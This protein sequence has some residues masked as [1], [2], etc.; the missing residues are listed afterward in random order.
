M[1][2]LKILEITN[3]TA[4]GCGVG[5]RVL[6]ESSLLVKKGYQVQIFSSFFVKGSNEIASKGEVIN[7]V[8]I[9][10]FPAKKLGG[11]SFMIWNFESEALKFNPDIIIVHAYRHIHTTR[12]LKIAKKL[13]AK[14]FLVTHAPFDR[15]STRTLFQRGTVFFYDQFIGKKTLKRFDKIIA[16]TKWEIPFILNLGLTRDKIEYIPNGIKDE[17]FRNN[18]KVKEENKIIYMGRISPIKNLKVMIKAIPLLD[19]TNTIFEIIGPCENNYLKKLVSLIKDI[20]LENRVKI[21]NKNYIYQEEIK[22]LNSAKFFILPSLSEGMPQVLVEAMALGKVVIASN[23]KGNADLIIDGKNGFLFKN[24]DEKDLA[25]KINK[26]SSIKK[27]K[28][29]NI[30]KEAKKTASQFSW[31]KIINKIEELINEKNK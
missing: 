31:D 2:K 13:N 11:E 15:N 25:E 10:R 30:K 26:I 18:K 9:K 27:D 22:Q 5:A 8:Q 28:F 29:N 19:N 1:K 3:Y 4:G 16:I 24:N 12:A 21:I 17:F 23:N 7:S 20:N 6:Q 14:I